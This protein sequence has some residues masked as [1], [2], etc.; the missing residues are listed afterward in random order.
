MD[1]IHT[2]TALHVEHEN[3]STYVYTL[4]EVGVCYL[5]SCCINHEPQHAG[6][7]SL[8]NNNL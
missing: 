8:L 2:N 1:T 6:L 5:D 7:D 3:I 4:E